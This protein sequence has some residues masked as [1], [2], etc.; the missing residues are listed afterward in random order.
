[1]VPDSIALDVLGF[2]QFKTAYQKLANS[3][4]S[5]CGGQL[6]RADFLKAIEVPYNQAFSQEHICKAFEITGTWP[7]NRNSIT[8]DQ[9]AP[10][11]GL[12]SC[13]VANISPISPVKAINKVLSQLPALLPSL[14]S[15]PDSTSP[16]PPT[17]DLQHAMEGLCK[18]LQDTHVSFLFDGSTTSSANEVQPLQFPPLSNIPNLDTLDNDEGS[19]PIDTMT[20]AELCAMILSLKME[21]KQVKNLSRGLI[22]DCTTL[23]SQLS[24]VHAE[25]KKLRSGLFKR[26]RK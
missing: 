25:N 8:P 16:N 23:I 18:T 19:I 15:P 14:A 10:S 6:T 24:L 11:I 21:M 1:M 17:S 5:E 12:S 2:T 13:G 26:E 20:K 22:Q 4:A 7:V 9:T 3:L